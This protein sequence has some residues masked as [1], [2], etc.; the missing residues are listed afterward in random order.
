MNEVLAYGS[1][2]KVRE[3]TR[4]IIDIL[5]SD[6]K[7]ILAPSH[8]YMLPELPARNIVAMYDEAKK[9]STGRQPNIKVK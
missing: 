2:E 3:E 1:E 6:G 7:Y 4:R 5:G 9:Y 8:D